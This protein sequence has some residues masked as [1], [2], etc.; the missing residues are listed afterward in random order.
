MIYFI[1]LKTKSSLMNHGI[2]IHI[3]LLVLK[4]TSAAYSSGLDWD[5]NPGWTIVNAA[6]QPLLLQLIINWLFKVNADAQRVQLICR[7][8]LENITLTIP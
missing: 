7:R 5:A 6:L 2:A 4:I 1:I 3:Q 8:K